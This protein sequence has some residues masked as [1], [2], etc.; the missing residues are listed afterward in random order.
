M[1]PL[2]YEDRLTFVSL[3]ET[4]KYEMSGYLNL[5]VDAEEMRGNEPAQ[6]AN[7]R[8]WLLRYGV[9]STP[10]AKGRGGK[11]KAA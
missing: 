10:E 9:T 1:S 8:K 7:L 2:S 11:K 3:L 4:P 5:E 6:E